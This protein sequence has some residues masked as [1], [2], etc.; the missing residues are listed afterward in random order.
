MRHLNVVFTAGIIIVGAA[1]IVIMA[2]PSA[3][4]R[5]P[6]SPEDKLDEFKLSDACVVEM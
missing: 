1:V 5:M 6:A 4:W 2:L 3:S